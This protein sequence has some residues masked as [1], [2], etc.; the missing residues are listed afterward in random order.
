MEVSQYE[1]GQIP[2]RNLTLTVKDTYGRPVDLRVYTSAEVRMLGSNNEEIDLTGSVLNTGG[3]ASGRYIFEWPRDRSLFTRSGEY[4]LQLVLK[5]ATA[6]DM[7][8][9]HTI[10]VRRLGRLSK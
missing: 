2:L 1:V 8:T 10:K 4:V 6:T 3:A 9:T 7:T 5:T